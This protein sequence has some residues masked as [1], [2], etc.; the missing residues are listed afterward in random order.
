MAMV[1]SSIGGRSAVRLYFPFVIPLWSF[2]MLVALVSSQSP[3]R[4]P[5]EIRQNA[6]APLPPC[7]RGAVCHA[8]EPCRATAECAAGECLVDTLAQCDATG[9][10]GSAVVFLLLLVATLTASGRWA[11]RVRG[12]G[13]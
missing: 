9:A 13:R 5:A 4:I 2:L 11:C 1:T 8:T 10:T 6:S 12:Y 3:T 7:V